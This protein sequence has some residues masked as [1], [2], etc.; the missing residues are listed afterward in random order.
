MSQESASDEALPDSSKTPGVRSALVFAV[1]GGLA[2]LV[3]APVVDRYDDHFPMVSLTVE[4]TNL[5]RAD[6]NDPV[7]WGI[8]RQNRWNWIFRNSALCLGMFGAILGAGLGLAECIR[9]R[10]PLK[11]IT[12]LALSVLLGVVG[13]VLSAAV[14]A[15]IGIRM[16]D[17]IGS[18]PLPYAVAMHIAAFCLI[19]MGIA[20]GMGLTTRRWSAVFRAFAGGL[21][22]GVM[23]APIAA[24]AFP[25]YETDLWIPHGLLPKFL[26]FGLAGLLLCLAIGR[27][28][29]R[30]ETTVATEP[31]HS[32]G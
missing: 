2:G 8:E 4:E 28:P 19:G 7:A 18:D 5:I 24:S 23:F 20:T 30:T 17:N 13:G 21:V 22:A 25:V 3:T 9:I 26:F 6:P 11:G 16:Q 27:T 15:S 29:T 32:E 31:L 12:V 1:V 14:D 10:K